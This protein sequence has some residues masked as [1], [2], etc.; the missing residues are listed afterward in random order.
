MKDRFQ[1]KQSESSRIS[2]RRRF[3]KS[4]AVLA[5]V[6]SACSDSQPVVDPNPG[7][8]GVPAS[9]YGKRSEFETSAR[10]TTPSST[11]EAGSSRTPLDEF[12][13]VLTPSSL[14]FERHHAGVPR[15]DPTQHRLLIHGTRG[16]L[17][18]TQ[19]SR[20]GSV[21]RISG[22]S[23]VTSSENQV[24]DGGYVA[25]FE[26]F[27]TAIATGER[28]VDSFAEAHRD[29]DVILQAIG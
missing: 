10:Q 7:T 26:A 2:S 17:E 29:L 15:I 1:I 4:S 20:T 12:Y 6:A 21:I 27:A 16:V 5:G 24:D 8:L 25:Q 11:P 9:A 22:T 14:H 28:S 13:G 23:G 19:N 18:V 3:L